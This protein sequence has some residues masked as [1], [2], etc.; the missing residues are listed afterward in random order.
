MQIKPRNEYVIVKMAGLSSL[1][2]KDVYF[3]E[4]KYVIERYAKNHGLTPEPDADRYLATGLSYKQAKKMM[5]LFK[6]N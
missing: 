1:G 6:E 2:A 3:M 4:R 5:K